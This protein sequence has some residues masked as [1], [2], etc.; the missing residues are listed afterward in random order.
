MTKAR[1]H[2]STSLATRPPNQALPMIDAK[3]RNTNG[4]QSSIAVETFRAGPRGQIPLR[5]HMVSFRTEGP[6]VERSRVRNLDQKRRLRCA[7]DAV[8][9]SSHHCLSS[10][11]T[12]EC[13]TSTVV[14]SKS[15][16]SRIVTMLEVAS[17]NESRLQLKT[18]LLLRH[19]R[20]SQLILSLEP[21]SVR[22]S[23]EKKPSTPNTRMQSALVSGAENHVSIYS[24]IVIAWKIRARSAFTLLLAE[25][26]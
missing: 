5:S 10:L 22:P 25:T 7:S 11:C 3:N 15:P 9:K 13:I 21:A 24:G 19:T 26:L 12:P 23:I 2:R 1:S 14:R 8:H 6:T 17:G 16:R 18:S 4:N 20:Y